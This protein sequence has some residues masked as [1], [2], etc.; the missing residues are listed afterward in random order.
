MSET[1]KKHSKTLYAMLRHTED[2][3]KLHEH[4]SEHLDWMRGN[5][6]DGRIFASGPTEPTAGC[7]LNGLTIIEANRARPPMRLLSR[8][9]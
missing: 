2:D 3:A 4:L 1:P 5:D 6:K 8:I 7:A 9:R